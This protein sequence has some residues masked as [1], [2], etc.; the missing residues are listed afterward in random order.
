MRFPTWLRFSHL[1]ERYTAVPA[2]W[3]DPLERAPGEPPAV[4]SPCGEPQRSVSLPE[5]GGPK[6]PPGPT[7]AAQSGGSNKWIYVR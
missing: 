6:G 4:P 3:F 7:G 2:G 1:L 5:K